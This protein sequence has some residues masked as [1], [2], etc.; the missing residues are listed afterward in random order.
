MKI[1]NVTKDEE[2][3]KVKWNNDG[4][5]TWMRFEKEQPDTILYKVTYNQAD[6]FKKMKVIRNLRLNKTSKSSGYILPKAF[7]RRLSISKAKLEDLLQLCNDLTI[8][9]AHHQFYRELT[10][11]DGEEEDD[12]PSESEEKDE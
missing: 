7:T 8:P 5:I 10:S 3:Q 2:G 11:K 12:C 1:T 9:T 6:P 4:S